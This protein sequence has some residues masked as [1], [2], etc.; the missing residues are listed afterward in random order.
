MKKLFLV[1]LATIACLSAIA[2]K[3]IG[4]YIS[5]DSGTPTNIRNAPG[6]QIVMSLP[7]T[8][9]YM[10]TLSNPRNG[11][12]RVEDVECAENATDIPLVG[13]SKGEYWIHYSVVGFTTRN[14]GNQRLCLRAE[15]SKKSKAV[16]WLVGETNVHPIDA[17][18]STDW[19][20][21]EANGHQGWIPSEMMC[22]NPLT[23]CP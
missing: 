3:E 7:D 12:W 9:S 8:C 19:V 1:A 20:K 2:Q 17:T 14:Y 18:K 22:Y 4:A 6:G 21:V 15:P 5:D 23:T 10:M 11:W 13:S 16:H